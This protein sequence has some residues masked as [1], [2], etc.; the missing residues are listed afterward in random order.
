M[1]DVPSTI[2]IPNT[3]P[4]R[5]QDL[6]E[7]VNG[8]NERLRDGRLENYR[9]VPLGFPQIDECL[10]GGLRAEDLALVGGMQN[11]G[12]TIFILQ[13]ARNLA[14]EGKVLP[15]LVCYEHSPETLLHRLICLESIDNPDDPHPVGV[16]RTGIEQAVL[17]YYYQAPDPAER[18][19]LDLDWILQR[20]PGVEKA[21][22]HMR[23]YLWRLWLVH[24]DG[25]ETTDYVLYEYVRMAQHMGFRRVLLMVDYAQ[26]VPLRPTV[27]GIELNEAQRID[28]VMRALKGI[29]MR[30][31]VPVLAV[32][33]ADAE[34]LRQQRVHFENLWGPATVQYEP[35]VALIMNRDTLEDESGARWVRLAVEKNRHGPSELEFRHKLRGAYYC[36]SRTGERVSEGESYQ[37]ERIEL[38]VQRR[39]TTQNVTLDRLVAM[40]L[41]AVL[42]QRDGAGKREPIQ[43]LLRRVAKADDGG[44][45]ILSEI[46]DRLDLRHAVEPD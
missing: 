26:R 6:W 28:L 25:L 43:S 29:A 18:R 35:D 4:Y 7:I 12:K 40:L 17:A 21:W 19:R 20:I 34:G 45:S 24:G 27:G 8:F 23:D 39:A 10:G 31:S 1:P 22:Y 9:P 16:T 11:V 46:A 30:L 3:A 44:V 41:V 42:E 36:L 32:A 5:P 13:V 38:R 37:V 33:A 14:A 15:I 2:Q